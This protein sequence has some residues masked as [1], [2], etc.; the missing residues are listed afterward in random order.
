MGYSR[1]TFYRFKELYENEGE[2]ALHEIS[3]K[4]PLL[5]NRVSDDIERADSNRISSIWARKSCK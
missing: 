4:K 1:D 5:A 3:K 2:E